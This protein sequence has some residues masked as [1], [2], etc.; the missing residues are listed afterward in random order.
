MA[1]FALLG[2]SLG[3]DG[4]GPGCE[5]A[6]EVG[7][8]NLQERSVYCEIVHIIEDADVYDTM[9]ANLLDCLPSYSRD[10]RKDLLDEFLAADDDDLVE[11][12]EDMAWSSPCYDGSDDDH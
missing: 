1:A 2:T 9:K 7:I 4:S 6:T 5:E 3:C 11:L 12:L 8:S 10:E